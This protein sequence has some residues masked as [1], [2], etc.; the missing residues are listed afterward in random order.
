MKE[1]T[2]SV[3]LFCLVFLL[4]LSSIA[5]SEAAATNDND[6]AKTYRNPIIDAIG[7]ADPTVILYKGTYY[8]Y[9]TWDGRGYDVFVSRDRPASH[10]RSAFVRG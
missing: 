9:P 8:L 6:K 1:K 5:V 7:P 10:H 2:I 3:T 4:C